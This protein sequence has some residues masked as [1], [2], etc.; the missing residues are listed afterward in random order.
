MA[1]TII[2][3]TV[4]QDIDCY[5]CGV[6]FAL[7]ERLYS[8]RLDDGANFYCP[9]GHQQHFTESTRD[10]LR[11]AEERLAEERRRTKAARDLLEHEER[12]HAATRGHLTR[13][14][15]R[16][17]AGVCPCCNRTFQQLARHMK[18]KHPEYVAEP[19]RV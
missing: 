12:S 18:T 4:F 8:Q 1:N 3:T 10:K 15:K 6:P 17:S 9:N 13:H 19:D 5:L 7:T 2:R 14:K 11:K 16:V